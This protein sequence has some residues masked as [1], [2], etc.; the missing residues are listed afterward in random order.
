MLKSIPTP[1]G[2]N[3]PAAEARGSEKPADEEYKRVI[4]LLRAELG[5]A[6][7]EL[8]RLKEGKGDGEGKEGDDASAKKIILRQEEEL[9][10]TKE[11]LATAQVELRAAESEAN[12]ARQHLADDEGRSSTIMSVVD[13]E[14]I[15]LRAE[16]DD[17]KEEIRVLQEKMSWANQELA[18]E[19]SAHARAQQSHMSLEVQLN[20]LEKQVQTQVQQQAQVMS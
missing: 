18:K 4:L 8:V 19:V 7:E 14:N 13:A 20:N 12:A 3:S 5:K 2:R 15:M 10:K 9:L 11:A 16:R 1:S 17:L 6:R